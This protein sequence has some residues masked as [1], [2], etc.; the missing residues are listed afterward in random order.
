MKRTA[1]LFAIALSA[2][3]A[4]LLAQSTP[5]VSD[6]PASAG[7]DAN[8]GYTSPRA[9]SAKKTPG[10]TPAPF[11]RIAFGGGISA[12]GINMQAAVNANR[13]MNLRGTGN[14]YNYT[15]NNLS[16]N[17]LNL[18]GKLNMA[19]AGASVDFYPF[20]YHGFR[21]SPGVLFYNQ[22]QVT[23]SVVAPGGTSFT[24]DGYTYYSSQANPVT[25]AGSVLLNKQ[26]PA[27]TITTG[28]GNMI[29]R[30]GGHFSVPF[31][32]GAAM[33]GSPTVNM[34]LTSGQVC[35][36]PQGTVGCQNV[37]GNSQINSNLAAQ[38]AKYQNDLNPF[39]FYPIVSVGVAYNF[40]IR[41]GATRVAA[42]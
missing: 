2:A 36:N 19:S 38:V 5:Y 8:G 23:A 20:P 28:W 9:I 14:F 40:S 3:A 39:R 4:S 25:G 32:I 1:L 34:A 24:L 21:I 16:V 33:I 30:R 10:A 11:S 31:E 6:A 13:Y 37:V 12:M 27:F 26:N 35:A 17:G 22:N 41:G 15:V 29:S 7:P 18:N 42:R